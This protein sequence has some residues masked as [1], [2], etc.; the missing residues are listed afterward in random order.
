M[1]IIVNILVDKFL[2]HYKY[3]F[4]TINLSSRIIG[5]PCFMVPA[6]VFLCDATY[7]FPWHATCQVNPAKNGHGFASA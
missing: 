7:K 6:P 1:F 2:S 3:L 4:V 5:I